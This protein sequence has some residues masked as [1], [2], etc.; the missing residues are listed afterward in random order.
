MS[1]VEKGSSTFH[2]IDG[3]T[4]KTMIIKRVASTDASDFLGTLN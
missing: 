3:G 2:V 1:D 4:N